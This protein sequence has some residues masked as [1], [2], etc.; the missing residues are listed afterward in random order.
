MADIIQGYDARTSSG[1]PENV[2]ATDVGT[3]RGLDVNMVGGSVTT[4]LGGLLGSLSYDFI[5]VT[6]PDA[7]TEVFTY[8]TGGSG[9]ST[10]AVIT[11]VYTSITKDY[12]LTVTKV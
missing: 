4:S 3:K 6:Y 2:T 1:T 7:I 11:V 10:V 12:V 5:A 8:K 9:G